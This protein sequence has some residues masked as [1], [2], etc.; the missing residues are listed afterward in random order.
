MAVPD[1]SVVHGSKARPQDLPAVDRLLR[2]PGVP[3]LLGEH[4]HTRVAAASAGSPGNTKTR[5]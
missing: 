5:P 1:G 3:G 4:G 2:A